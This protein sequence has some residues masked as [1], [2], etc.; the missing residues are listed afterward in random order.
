MSQIMDT[1][2]VMLHTEVRST[3]DQGSFARSSQSNAPKLE[4]L[5][6]NP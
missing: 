5:N 6:R 1:M 3:D 2:N 4:T